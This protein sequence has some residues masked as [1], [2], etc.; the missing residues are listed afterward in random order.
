V[1]FPEY[2][3]VVADSLST[4]TNCDSTIRTAT[5]YYTQLL[6]TEQGRTKIQ[7]DFK[8]C[9]S[10]KT[11]LDITTFLE[12]MSDTISGFVQYNNDNNKY[13]PFNMG[14]MCEML[15]SRPINESFPS[16]FSAWNNFAGSCSESSYDSGLADLEN[17]DPKSPVAAGRAWYWQ[18][19]TEFG[20][21]QTGESSKSLFSPKIT[22]DYFL[23]MCE[24]AFG[25]TKVEV[26]ANVEWTNEYYGARN[27][28]ATRIMF[29]NGMV[30]PWHA[31]GI[32]KSTDL[33]TV[34]MAGTAHCADLYPSRKEDLPIL[35]QTRET[36]VKILKIWLDQ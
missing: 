4:F 23:G 1:D 14:T 28:S 36:F 27:I 18:T 22:L 12:Y 9:S 16:F 20:Y 26:Q 32:T 3:E 2:F 8:T 34:L 17:I 30:D 7:Q 10:I 25:I 31:L 24:A 5:D 6:N 29:T 33:P 11:E 15:T 19:C 13:F 21:Y 35:T